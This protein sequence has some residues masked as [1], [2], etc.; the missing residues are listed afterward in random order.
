[1]NLRGYVYHPNNP[2]FSRLVLPFAAITKF[3]QQIY[4]FLLQA[5]WQELLSG[6]KIE[7]ETANL[8]LLIIFCIFSWVAFQLQAYRQFIIVCCF[9]LW[10][11]DRA[12]AQQYYNNNSKSKLPVF[13]QITP[14]TLYIKNCLPQCQ[15]ID[16]AFNR[17]NLKEIAIAPRI[18]TSNAFQAEIK[19][20]WQVLIYGHNQTEILVDEQTKLATAFNKAK[21]LASILEVPIIFQGSEGNHAYAE[22]KLFFDNEFN[23]TAIQIEQNQNKRHI[24]SQWGLP[25]SWQ[26]FKQILTESGFII[27]III[28]TNFMIIWGGLLD[29][30][31]LGRQDTDFNFSSIWQWLNPQFNLAD[32]LELLIAIGVLIVEG[33]RISQTKHIYLDDISLKYLVRNQ[34]KGQVRIASIEAIL[35][36]LNPEPNL[37][38]LAN[39]KALTIAH[40]PTT[41]AYREMIQKL[42]AVINQKLATD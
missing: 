36:M 11:I 30:F 1:M 21:Y 41:D 27:F 15:T 34:I 22:N 42:E 29:E 17:E 16:L 13:L 9:S 40:L 5:I 2:L 6:K 18:I 33:I 12:I 10:L 35:L 14:D 31:F 37:L 19:Q 24:Y 4:E 32:Y 8:L 3:L 38:I 25:N 39:N 23:L 20:C 26:L 28:I 7:S